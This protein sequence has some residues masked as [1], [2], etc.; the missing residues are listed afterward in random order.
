MREAQPRFLGVV[1][2]RGVIDA[3]DPSQLSYFTRP[4][5]VVPPPVS[6]RNVALLSIFWL[7][8]GGLVLMGG[9]QLVQLI[10]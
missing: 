1:Y 4:Q 7:L 10:L 2:N 8:V 3:P 5:P 6:L 9:V